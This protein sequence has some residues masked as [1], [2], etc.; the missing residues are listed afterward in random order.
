V[1]GEGK[2][3]EVGSLRKDDNSTLSENNKTRDKEMGDGGPR[4]TN[5]TA[6]VSVIQLPCPVLPDVRKI[7]EN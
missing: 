5:P 7:E 6:Q 4:K 2:K 3:G 1:G